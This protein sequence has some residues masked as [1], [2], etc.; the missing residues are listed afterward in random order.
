M[1]RIWSRGAMATKHSVV[2]R[3]TSLLHST[4]INQ[5]LVLKMFKTVLLGCT[6][7]PPAVCASV[8][9]GVWHITQRGYMGGSC[10]LLKLRW[11]GTQRV[12]MNGV[13]LWLVRWECRASTWVFC[14]SLAA[15]VGPEQNI[16]S[17]LF[18]I[19]IPLSTFPSKLGRQ[20]CCDTCLLV[21]VSGINTALKWK[22]RITW[23]AV[24]ILAS[25]M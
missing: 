17:S 18:S 3:P 20:S 2:R 6:D 1:W 24:P 16:F 15:L 23:E 19:S 13:L 25:Y 12:Q 4:Y 21:C 22:K 14:P 8:N 11:M 5:V 9:W 7:T 10:G